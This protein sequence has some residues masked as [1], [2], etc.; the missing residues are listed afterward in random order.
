MLRVQTA[1]LWGGGDIV[2][3]IVIY[4]RGAP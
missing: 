4:F 2:L 3:K 1:D